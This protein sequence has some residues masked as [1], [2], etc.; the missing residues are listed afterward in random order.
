MRTV[1][2]ALVVGFVGSQGAV[3]VCW[4]MPCQMVA[5]YYRTI[6]FDDTCANHDYIAWYQDVEC[7]DHAGV[8]CY[9]A[10]CKESFFLTRTAYTLIDPSDYLPDD[11]NCYTIELTLTFIYN[12]SGTW[13]DCDGD[14][15]CDCCS[16]QGPLGQIEQHFVDRYLC[17]CD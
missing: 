14:G 4:P 8:A 7:P 12:G 9:G 16:G 1:L 3:A 6:H 5:H 15:A 11:E 13:N 10:T 2:F 17:D